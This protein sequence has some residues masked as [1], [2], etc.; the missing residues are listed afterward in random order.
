MDFIDLR[1]DTVT[2]PT[3]SML[4]A[5]AE[6]RVGDDVYR[7]DPSVNQLE[8]K[9]ASL[10]GKEASLFVPSGTFG[11][12]LAILTHTQRG[13]EVIIGQGNHIVQHEVAAPAFIAGVQLRTIKDNH[14]H[15]DMEEVD[16]LVR[17]QDIHYPRTGLICAE[18][19]H[20]DGTVISL[21]EMEALYRLAKKHNI[22][23]HL[24]GARIFNAAACIK[25]EVSELASLCDSLMFC[26]SKGLCCPVGSMLC[27]KAGFIG[28]ARKFRKLMGGGLRQAGYLAACGLVALDEMVPRLGQDHENAKYLARKLEAIEGIWVEKERLDINMVFFKADTKILS[29]DKFIDYML[30][31]GIKIGPALKGY[32]RLVTHYWIKKE[33]L[34]HTALSIEKYMKGKG[35]TGG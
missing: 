19:A 27:G 22:P 7:D 12:Q 17:G 25:A 4:R 18:N 11:N 34:D 3:V 5:M 16:S 26:L 10:M 15:L 20:S 35:E 9:A 13:D 33:D 23:L 32:F 21:A 6:A 31:S 8:Q 2:K 24:D 28:R 30:K 14:G 29:Q 1:S